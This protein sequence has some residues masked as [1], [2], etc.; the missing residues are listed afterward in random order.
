MLIIPL[1]SLFVP[2]NRQRK[3][4]NQDALTAL[5]TSI[6]T[7]GLL[8]PP[9]VVEEEGKYRLVAGERRVRAITSLSELDIPF[10]CGRESI[11]SGNIPVTLLSELD[12]LALKEVELEENTIRTD[13]TWQE[14]VA[15]RAE[16][17]SLRQAQNPSHTIADTAR[18]VFGSSKGSSSMA[19]REAV[20]LQPHL[21]DPEISKAK[22]QTEAIKILEKK[23]EREYRENLAATIVPSQS[24]FT[25]LPGDFFEVSQQLPSNEFDCI[26]TDPPYG[27]GADSFGDQ[28]NLRHNY[29][30]DPETVE[31]LLKTVARESFRVSRPAAHAYCFCSFEWFARLSD[32]WVEAGW[33]VWPRPII[34]YK[35]NHGFLPRPNHGPR[36]TYEC[37]L[38]AIKGNKETYEIAHDVIS[39]PFVEERIHAAQKPTRL[40]L[41]LLAR[42]C[43]PGDKVVDFFA[44]SG[45]IFRAA[46]KA[47]LKATGIEKDPEHIGSCKETILAEEI[48]VD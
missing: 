6:R 13:L 7:H 25:I 38:F 12:P 42:S 40:Y 30:D 10:V 24:D 14:L 35:G 23:K 9:V 41:N 5:A 47:K 26:L 27:I 3:E 15:A 8:H 2:S 4:F 1:S 45:T 29:S 22:S 17:N 46:K 18:E 19:I 39:L 43:L 28:A 16:L 21:N 32:M 34:W 37:I 36:Y 33:S 31:K 44:G 11:S 48:D 20:I